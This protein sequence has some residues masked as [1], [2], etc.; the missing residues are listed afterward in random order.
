MINNYNDDTLRNIGIKDEYFLFCQLW[1]ELTD[2][3][4]FDS[5]QFKSFNIINGIDELIHNIDS[6]LNGLVATTHSICS[7]SEEVIKYINRDPVLSKRFFTIRNLLLKVLC[8]KHE[9]PNELKAL[10]YQLELY[11]K[12][13]TSNYDD[14]LIEILT[15]SIEAQDNNATITLTASFISRCID[16][17]WSSKALFSKLDLSYGKDL[18]DFLKKIINYPKQTYVFLFPFRKIEIIPPKGKTKEASKN[19]VKEQL[20][21]FDITVLSKDEVICRYS[22]INTD[23]LKEDEYISVM[24]DG[25]DIY[26]SSHNAIVSLSNVLNILSFFSA[27]EPW[28]VKNK[29]WIGYNTEAPYSISLK[30][31]DIYRTYEYLDSSSTVYN[32]IERLMH[33][34]SNNL[35][36]YQKL[37]SAF[38]YTNLSHSSM[39]VEEKYMNMWIALE[40]LTRTDAHS[41]II[42]NIIEC[43]PNACSLRYVYR[44]IRNF[45]E[46][47]GRCNV[48][49]D[50]GSININLQENNKEQIVSQILTILRDEALTQILLERCKTCSLLHHRCQ[51]FLGFVVNE[52]AFIMHIKSQHKTIEWHLD[53][54]YR[55]RNEIAHSAL[56]QH[57]SIV[58]YTEHLYDY[59]ATYISELVRFATKKDILTFGVLSATI[60]D[61]YHEFEFISNQKKLKDKKDFLGT[62]WNSG[63]M[64]FI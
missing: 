5:Y 18:K 21:K 12:E 17:G 32:R 58:R 49:L 3:R 2:E 20:N 8:N 24:S 48:S 9:T 31:I 22:D 50:F 36:L 63:I 7:V 43:I 64:D 23:L 54:L 13:L 44:E 14:A 28:S 1:K 39:T 51:E 57:V 26:T 30:P 60:N 19:Y 37:L 35:E 10:R 52:Q 56:F 33:T 34:E 38:S 59:L 47:C 61:N 27:I 25:K 11:G 41:G 6:F 40:S 55:I 53:R 42:S 29:T 4:T 62:L 16:L 15:Q 46:D 45:A